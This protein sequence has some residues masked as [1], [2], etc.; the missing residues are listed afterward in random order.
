M[1]KT[2]VSFHQKISSRLGLTCDSVMEA[3]V[4]AKLRKLSSVKKLLRSVTSEVRISA[5]GM[6]RGRSQLIYVD[7]ESQNKGSQVSQWTTRE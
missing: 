3:E 7:M 2:E 6:N 5:M 4:A 1:I